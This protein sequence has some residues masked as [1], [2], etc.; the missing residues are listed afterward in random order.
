MRENTRRLILFSITLLFIISTILIIALFY[1]QKEIKDSGSKDDE[2]IGGNILD[3]YIDKK[4]NNISQR[5]YFD[6]NTCVGQ[7]LNV[8]NINSSSYYGYDENEEYTIV[9]DEKEIKQ[10]IYDVLSKT[11]IKKNNITIENLYNNVKTINEDAIYVPLEALVLE[12]G[13][14]QSFIIHGLVETF[15]LKVI[16]ELF[17]ILNIDKIN[18]VFSIEPIYGNY[19]SVNEIKINRIDNEIDINDNNQF[20]TVSISN[21]NIARDYL[22]LYK[23]LALGSPENLY[24][25]LDEEY[26]NKR[27][28]NLEQFKKYISEN[29]EK[30]T[31][32]RVEKYQRN[33]E[34]NYTQ[35]ISIDQNDNYYI[36]MEI[37][38]LQYKIILDNYTI[39][40]KEFEEKYNKSSEVEKVILNIKKFFMGIDDENYGYS[41]SVLSEAFKNNNYPTKNDFVNYAKSN[42][43]NQ[44]EVEYVSYKKQNDLYIYE[45]KLK[46]ATGNNKEEKTF[47]IILKLNS[48]TDF[49]MSFGQ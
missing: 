33:T 32:A 39:P 13:N 47:N 19:K 45:I 41:Y 18:N 46:D 9:I 23:R 29:K 22:N 38:P 6:I 3:D 20:T 7:Y 34:K 44:N 21:E 16:D 12:N 11:Y 17:A 1:L 42:F 36:F 2:I 31:S 14:I 28:E 5:A 48:G 30:I 43:F 37:A 27:F 24:N 8:L 15:E 10:N 35:Y 26:R 4:E 25:M 40:T 49:E